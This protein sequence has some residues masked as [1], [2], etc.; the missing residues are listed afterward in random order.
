MKPAFD[1][2]LFDLGGVLI[3]ISG[4][5]ETMGFMKEPVSVAEF[6]RRWLFCSGVR[7]FESGQCDSERFAA[8]VVEELDL[9]VTPA[10][11]IES[12][13][14]WIKGPYSGTETLL[15]NLS[16]QISVGCLSNTNPL[17]WP[18]VSENMALGR[19]FKHPLI[20]Y[21]IGMMKPD[22]EIFEYAVQKT[23]YQPSRIL[24]FDDNEI[25]VQSAQ[26]C[27][28]TALYVRGPEEATNELKKLGFAV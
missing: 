4:S 2:I 23:G 21:Q 20:S 28:L 15:K 22:A 25:N 27:G 11:F 13:K 18:E 8:R 14:Q 26:R 9:A 6:W 24:F 7:A 19:Y 5:S 17:H 12:F 10:G 1:L 16:T 3:D